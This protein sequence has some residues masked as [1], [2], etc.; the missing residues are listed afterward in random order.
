MSRVGKHSVS[1][2]AAVS[3]VRDGNVFSIKGKLGENSV[4]VP[5]CISVEQAGNELTVAPKETT[6]FARSMWGTIQRNL[7][8]AVKGVSEG[9]TVN[10]D[11]IGVGYKAAVSGQTLVLQLGYSHDVEYAI[12]AGVV[13]KCEKPTQISVTTSSKQ[14][15]GS[16]AAQL[17][18]Y[19]PPEPYKGKGVIRSGEFI[20]RKEG[21]KK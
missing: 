12:P 15:T 8:N 13:I 11:L 6:T 18:S 17:R 14:L 7:N 9:F 2:P 10:L 4:P 5:D 16:I 21:K 1:I 19:R 20:V 3:V